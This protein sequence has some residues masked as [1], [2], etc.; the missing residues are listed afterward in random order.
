MGGSDLTGSSGGG[1]GGRGLALA[2]LHVA[3]RDFMEHL[4]TVCGHWT[5]RRPR[6]VTTVAV[7]TGP[8]TCRAADSLFSAH[9]PALLAFP[10]S[11][12][13]NE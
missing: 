5:H 13:G 9:S 6:Q 10:S 12:R 4:L 11:R 2:A 1:G 7:I 8:G 3:S